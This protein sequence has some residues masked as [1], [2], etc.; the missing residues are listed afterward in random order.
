MDGL[1]INGNGVTCIHKPARK[2]GGGK[3]EPFVT[4]DCTALVP[5]ISLGVQSCRQGRC[6]KSM[7]EHWKEL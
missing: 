7:Q 6:S 2:G 4:E 3:M 5:F 1:H